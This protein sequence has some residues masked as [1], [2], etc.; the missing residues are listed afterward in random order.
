MVTQVLRFSGQKLLKSDRL[1]GVWK[2][3]GNDGY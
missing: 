3:N 2:V 1:Q